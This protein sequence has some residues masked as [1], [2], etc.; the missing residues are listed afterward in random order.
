MP[1][2]TRNEN[3]E[4]SPINPQ[5]KERQLQ[6]DFNQFIEDF[7][8]ISNEEQSGFLNSMA[9]NDPHFRELFNQ[10]KQF[11]QWKVIELDKFDTSVWENVESQNETIEI[12]EEQIKDFVLKWKQELSKIQE[13]KN[14]KVEQKI[15]HLDLILDIS[16][17]YKEYLQDILWNI[18]AKFLSQKDDRYEKQ[19][20]VMEDE[21]RNI[22]NT[23]EYIDLIWN[24]DELLNL[25]INELLDKLIVSEEKIQWLW[26]IDD[27]FND[28]EF[29]NIWYDIIKRLLADPN[30][31]QK[32][33]EKLKLD[34][35]SKI[36]SFDWVDDDK[37]RYNSW[38]AIRTRITSNILNNRELNNDNSIESSFNFIK[39]FSDKDKVNL[40][41]SINSW[42]DGLNSFFEKNNFYET[43]WVA[44]NETKQSILNKL[45]DN[46]NKWKN[47]IDDWKLKELIKNEIDSKI[48]YLENQLKTSD[49]KKDIQEKINELK[50]AIDGKNINTLI[51]NI[52]IE[53]IYKS[54]ENF[55]INETLEKKSSLV[56]E[57]SKTNND[58]DLYWDIEW[59]WSGISDENFNKVSS[60][61]Q[62]LAE[63]ITIM[64][65]SWLV[66]KLALMWVWKYMT[67]WKTTS[68]FK[69]W[70]NRAN[71][72][73]I[74]V[75]SSIE[76]GAFYLWY[77]WMNWLTNKKEASEAF[78]DLKGYDTIRTV[79]FL[80]VLRSISNTTDLFNVKNIVLDTRNVLWTDLVIR[81]LSD[82][83]TWKEWIEWIDLRNLKNSD[84]K[85]VSK[86]LV[87]EL[88]FIIPLI[89]WLRMADRTFSWSNL[90][91]I[92]VIPWENDYLVR[93][94]WIKKE[95]RILKQ[96]R[97]SLRSKWRDIWDI[98]NVIQEKKAEYKNMRD[99]PPDDLPV[100]EI[101]NK[102]IQ[103]NQANSN[104]KKVAPKKGGAD[105]NTNMNTWEPSKYLNL[106]KYSKEAQEW[107]IDYA[108][109]DEF[110][111][112]TLTTSWMK[113]WQ[114]VWEWLL[115]KSWFDEN[116]IKDFNEW[117]LK[118]ETAE[119]PYEKRALREMEK[120]NEVVYKEYVKWIIK[121]SEWY[122]LN[123]AFPNL[124]KDLLLKLKKIISISK[125]WK[126]ERL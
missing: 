35:F 116:E 71:I 105:E 95:I 50:L 94:Q 96:N 92:E 117:K 81:W 32:D 103:E 33:I 6:N 75:N 48:L 9:E 104:K 77:T 51:E 8:R 26:R 113:K 84:L 74:A 122:S 37:H 107:K 112:D 38:E 108:L 69:W 14:E 67:I 24:T 23:T 11:F 12:S 72:K 63:Q 109:K 59:I 98:N 43:L 10:L 115:K 101:G 124:T 102:I 111:W 34:I 36:R 3:I 53:T 86:F 93:F 97:N 114:W 123:E 22:S 52:K 46:L 87:N 19:I 110:I 40:Y 83:I 15:T 120:A 4:S 73:N 89:I 16:S 45:Y 64:Y 79:M 13:E 21:I 25:N 65:L 78:D 100:W 118:S 88:E 41:N 42:K 1:I 76:W 27:F 17:M 61:T 47:N 121:V 106:E 39:N 68:I 56:W 70:L 5:E 62:F 29:V 54:F 44:D 58:I 7:S 82:L 80:W 66:W 126:K 57:L 85:E 49:N 28:P 31:G 91:E 60:W 30:V 125:E 90:K 99:N 2:E 20:K 55:V 18:K 119:K